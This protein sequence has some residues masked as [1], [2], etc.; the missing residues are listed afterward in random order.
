MNRTFRYGYVQAKLH[1][2]IGSS[3]VRRDIGPLVRSNDVREIALELFPERRYDLPEKALVW[4]LQQDLDER[5]FGIIRRILLSLNP[6]PPVIIHL[7]R[8]YELRM[9]RSLVS[10]VIRMPEDAEGQIDRAVKIGPYH[11]LGPFATLHPTSAGELSLRTLE[12]TRFAWILD[13]IGKDGLF[14]IE[15]RLDRQFYQEM[16]GYVRTVPKRE[17]R[18]VEKL[19]LLEVNLQNYIWILRLRIFFKQTSEQILPLLVPIGGRFPD[20]LTETLLTMPLDNQE[21]LRGFP[22]TWLFRNQPATDFRGVDPAV[23]EVQAEMQLYRMAKRYFYGNP[24]TLELVYAF[25]KLK[26]FEVSRVT[27]LLEGLK[28]SLPESELLAAAGAL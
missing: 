12:G 15:S 9:V 26:Q 1:G 20:R 28:M 8:T 11:D 23:A 14:E 10:A 6:P 17:R 2:L 24:F 22:A 13:V 25:C 18:G 19:V 5:L 16:L 27:T 7:L 3:F 21:A 4:R